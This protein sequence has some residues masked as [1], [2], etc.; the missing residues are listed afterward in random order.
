MTQT[1]WT[2]NRVIADSPI[3]LF[4]RFLNTFNI[5]PEVKRINR[6]ENPAQSDFESHYNTCNNNITPMVLFLKLSPAK[7]AAQHCHQQRL[8]CKYMCNVIY[9]LQL[10]NMLSGLEL[11]YWMCERNARKIVL[12]SR[13]GVR[14]AYQKWMILR[15]EQKGAKVQVSSNQNVNQKSWN[16]IRCPGRYLLLIKKLRF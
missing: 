15:M 1:E 7:C 10:L 4:R 16:Q 13:S 6:E 5:S 3:N 11:A 12:T 2:V 9:K 8:L 14:T